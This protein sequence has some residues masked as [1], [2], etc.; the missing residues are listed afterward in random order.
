MPTVVV[1]TRRA[2]CEAL[3]DAAIDRTPVGRLITRL[4][5]DVDA[6]QSM[7]TDGIVGLIADVGILVGLT[8]Y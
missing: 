7:M 4:T 2:R 1:A 3:L 5:S 8:I 6:I